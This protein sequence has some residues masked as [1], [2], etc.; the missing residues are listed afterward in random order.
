MS[1]PAWAVK[2]AAD[3]CETAGVEVPVLTWRRSADAVKSSGRYYGTERRIVVTTGRDRKDQ[4][5]VLLHELA[6]HLTP[7][8]KHSRAFWQVAWTLYGRFGL[9][10]YG[11]DRDGAYRVAAL[12]VA[13]DMG[14][15][16]SHAATRRVKVKRKAMRRPRGV[17][18]M[19]EHLAAEDG[20]GT[21]HT[22]YVGT[23]HRHNYGPGLFTD[24]W[25]ERVR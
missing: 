23:V 13:R 5:F 22:H 1:A 21:P 19:P 17:C 25:T 15:R 14:I 7:K 12:A 6:H 2:L 3:V 11:L 20:Y 8:A 16:G 18:P 10:R 24:Y 9:A 4:R